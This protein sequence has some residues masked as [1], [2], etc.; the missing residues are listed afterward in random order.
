MHHGIGLSN[1]RSAMRMNALYPLA[2]VL[3]ASPATRLEAK[4]PL[5]G[6]HYIHC[7]SDGNVVRLE[8]DHLGFA[9]DSLEAHLERDGARIAELTSS[10]LGYIDQDVPPGAHVYRLS[11]TQDQSTL[12]STECI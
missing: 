12:D 3:L 7:L 1:W 5:P 8:W 2:A 10:D 4:H 9:G 6:P 11:I